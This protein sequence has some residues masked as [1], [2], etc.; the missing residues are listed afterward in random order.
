M[1]RNAYR[2]TKKVQK[3]K[4]QKTLHVHSFVIFVSIKK[5]AK[6]NFLS[7]DPSPKE[8]CSNAATTTLRRKVVMSATVI[9]KNIKL[10]NLNSFQVQMNACVCVRSLYKQ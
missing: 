10:K 5:R 9:L 1:P 3:L 8:S 4:N 2:L 6:Q 7:I